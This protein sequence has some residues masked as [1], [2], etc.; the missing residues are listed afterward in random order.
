VLQPDVSFTKIVM[1]IL[2]DRFKQHNTSSLL[3]RATYKQL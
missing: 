2:L 1:E 3:G